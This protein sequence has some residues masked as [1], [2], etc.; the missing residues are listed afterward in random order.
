MCGPV[1]AQKKK[2]K[3]KKKSL[4]CS[5]EK[6]VVKMHFYPAKKRL[7]SC[8]STVCENNSFWS[9]YIGHRGDVEGHYR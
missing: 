1:F 4:Q 5:W 3:K 6:D 7:P 8:K 2:E 9:S